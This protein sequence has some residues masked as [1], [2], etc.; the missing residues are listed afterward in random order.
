MLGDKITSVTSDADIEEAI[1]QIEGIIDTI[2]KVGG[3]D[4]GAN[5]L[6]FSTAKSAHYTIK[7]AAT[8]GAVL[9]LIGACTPSI[10]TMEQAVMMRENAAWGYDEAMKL[11]KDKDESFGDFVLKR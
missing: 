11:L 4:T 3:S 1:N 10:A 5:A 9:L 6:T 8:C 2:L 7:T